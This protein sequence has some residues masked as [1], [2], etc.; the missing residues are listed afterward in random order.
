MRETCRLA[1]IL[2]TSIS[3]RTRALCRGR[4]EIF[5]RRHHVSV[6]VC[7]R[8]ILRECA[9]VIVYKTRSGVTVSAGWCLPRWVDDQI[10]GR[11]VQAS[12]DEG[13]RTECR[14][15]EKGA[16]DK[17][18][19]VNDHMQRGCRYTLS[20]PAGR[21]FDPGFQPELTP[22]EMLALGVFGGRYMTDCQHEYPNS[23]WRHAKL[24]LGGTGY[25]ADLLWNQCG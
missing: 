10:F 2:C 17:S 6:Y 3:T 20:A 23:W 11:A 19:I 22:K 13:T 4:F 8:E 1:Q 16:K 25:L 14:K 18:V 5:V 21:D 9:R 15:Y 7:D 24:S 12:P